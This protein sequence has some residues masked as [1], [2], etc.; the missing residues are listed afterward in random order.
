MEVSPSDLQPS[1][2]EDEFVLSGDAITRN[3]QEL[4]G[5]DMSIETMLSD[6]LVFRFPKENSKKVPVHPNFSMTLTP[7]YINSGSLS[8]EPDSVTIYG[9]PYKL[10]NIDRVYTQSFALNDLKKSVSGEVML[11]PIKGV[12][13]SDEKITYGMEV[14]RY[15]EITA[16]MT[17][18]VRN[19]PSGKSL[20][21]YPGTAKVSFRCA[22]PVSVSPQDKVHFYIDYKDFAK[23]LAGQCLPRRDALPAGVI[24]YT[25][26]P[27]VFEC[28]ESVR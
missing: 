10:E 13:F 16:N 3:A 6:K 28:M 14:V 11:E 12:R 26:T 5:A 25:M 17:V 7:Q 19:V 2:V 8:M 27:D 1:G 20:S 22:F 24:S 18:G 21:V 4:L 15:V 9:E 23:S